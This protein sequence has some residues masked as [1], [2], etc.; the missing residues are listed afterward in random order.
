LKLFDVNILIYAHRQDQQ[1]HDFYRS[2]VESLV[3]GSASFGLSP[4]TAV[5]FVRIVTHPKFPNGPTPLAQALSVVESLT[6][7]E[8]CVWTPPGRRNWELTRELC[9]KTRSAGKGVADAQHAAVAVEHA[10]DWITRDRDFRRFE[11]HGL[12]LQLLEP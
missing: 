11:P 9:Q 3:N 6:S 7:L 2:F 8:H 1:H 5:G 12:K 4:L 10:C